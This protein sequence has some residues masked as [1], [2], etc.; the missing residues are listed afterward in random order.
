MYT[1][2]PIGCERES[3]VIAWHA[4]GSY[5]Y[6]TATGGTTWTLA[7]AKRFDAAAASRFFATALAPL[8][9]S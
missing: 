4:E 9:T 7:N 8:P 3:W 5:A 6:V 2:I 1:V